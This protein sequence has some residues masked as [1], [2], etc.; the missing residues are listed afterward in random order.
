[1]NIIA[2]W[3]QRPGIVQ[4]CLAVALVVGSLAVG[5]RPAD[6]ATAAAAQ[7]PVAGVGEFRQVSTRP[8]LEQGKPVVLYVGAQFCPFCAAERWALVLATSRF[9][10]WSGLRPMQSTAGES[11]F[12]SLATYDLLHAS[13]HSVLI[14]VQTR[15]VAD[16]AGNPLQQLTARQTGAVNRYDPQ[17]GIPFV[18]VAGRWGQV[19]AGY[20]PA[21]LMGLTFARIHTLIYAQ[22]ASTLSVHATREANVL[23]A[24]VCTALGARARPL[25][26]CRIPQ[27]RTFIAEVGHL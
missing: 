9:G 21:L 11:G 20:S 17:G 14:V 6:M 13:Y 15:E 22:P 8:W 24:L 23:T 26:G 19:S 12:P 18:L 10:R 7:T 3:G 16:F 5:G 25:A 2:S 4:F 27:V 1:L